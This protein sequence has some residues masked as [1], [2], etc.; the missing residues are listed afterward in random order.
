MFSWKKAAV[1]LAAVALALTGCSAGGSG[2]STASGGTL[3]LGLI[4]PASN[5]SAQGASW[6]NESP[7]MQ[8][9]YDTLLK[10]EADGTI[11]ANL[12]TDWSYNADNTVLTMTLR[13]DVKFTDGTPF[14]A[15]AAAQNLVRFRDGTSPNASFLANLKD[16]T[17]IDDTHVQLTLKAPDPALLTYL[18]QN[19]GLQESPAAFGN[20]D[21]KTVPVGSGPYT[22]N[23]GETVVGNSYVFDKNPNYWN[24]SDQ[25]YD[26][27]VMN[28]YADSTSLLNA[29]Q[30]GQVNASTTINNTILPQIESAGYTLSPIENNWWGL[31]IGDR[32]GTL[33][34][35]IG[36]VKVRQALNYAFDRNAML[37]AFTDGHGTVTE[38]I[39]P[40]KSTSYDPALDQTYSYDPAKARQ[41]LAEAGYPNG[42]DLRMPS[43]AAFGASN[44]A[45]IQQ[46]LADVGIRVTYDELQVNDYITALVSGKYPVAL[47]ALQL[48][49]T[50]WQLSQ[51]SIDKSATFNGFHTDDPMVQGYIATLQTGSKADA[52]AAGKALNKYIVDQ[53]W[54]A[55]WFRPA[56]NFVSDPNTDLT[57]QVGN[58][59]PYLWNIKPKN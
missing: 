50:D 14:N 34:P 57:V 7:Y 39:F 35:A 43:S 44:F 42:F 54:F 48:D 26:K 56:L 27:L 32:N 22:L 36:N 33:N 59:Y 41:L 29:I 15:Q 23:V 28:Y 25:H 13:D 4:T 8:A 1:V 38:Q 5:F 55:P 3:T 45:L 21:V 11:V 18:T 6:A 58:S 49:P 53:G 30:G 51:F 17:A 31:I 9:V 24:P 12:A 52:E 2:G 20:A 40:T 37:T 10:A 19:A 46:Q 47:M 16:A